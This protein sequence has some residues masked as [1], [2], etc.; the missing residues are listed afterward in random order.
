MYERYVSSVGHSGTATTPLCYDEYSYSQPLS[1]VAMYATT[2]SSGNNN[3]NNYEDNDRRNESN[4]HNP[5]SFRS[6]AGRSSNYYPNPSS[7]DS[8]SNRS[9]PPTAATSAAAPTTTMDHHHPTN[10]YAQS[11]PAQHGLPHP[12][13]GIPLPPTTQPQEPTIPPTRL[14]RRILELTSKR[15]RT[16]DFV[17][18]HV[19]QPHEVLDTPSFIARCPT[20]STT[21]AFDEAAVV[22][23]CSNCQ[24]V[25]LVAVCDIVER[26]KK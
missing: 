18:G 17:Q 11:Q 8:P 16:P 20:C 3:N 21:L 4:N 9:I 24:A 23:R 14:G 10:N 19:V 26:R 2:P 7:L 15:T 5:S 6:S 13:P 1:L 22:L 25:H 12:K